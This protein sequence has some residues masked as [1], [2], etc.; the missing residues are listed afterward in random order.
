MDEKEKIQEAYEKTVLSEGMF[1][2]AIDD[3]IRK[4][5]TRVSGKEQAK[6]LGVMYLQEFIDL[7]KMMQR[8]DDADLP[9]ARDY[10][11]KQLPDIKKALQAIKSIKE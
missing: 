10:M 6:R 11:V 8:M 7:I 3:I 9:K 4:L 5:T 1:T 2:T